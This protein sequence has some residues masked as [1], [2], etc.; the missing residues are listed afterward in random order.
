MKF[1]IKKLLKES[2]DNRGYQ[3]IKKLF[4][5]NDDIE[6]HIQIFIDNWASG[7]E[8]SNLYGEEITSVQMCKDDNECICEFYRDMVDWCK[9]MLQKDDFLKKLVFDEDDTLFYLRPYSYMEL[10]FSG[11]EVMNY[12]RRLFIELSEKNDC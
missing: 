1:L 11:E 10:G 9:I 5:I 6:F 12:Y 7:M 8:M 3:V 4:T 2:V